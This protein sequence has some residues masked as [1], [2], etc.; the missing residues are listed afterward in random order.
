MEP[1]GGFDHNAQALRVVTLLERRYA[2]YDGLDLTWETLEGSSNTMARSRGPRRRVRFPRYV[3]EFDA[4]FPLELR[5]FASVEAQAAA[6]ADDIA[7]NR[8]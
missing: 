1:Y 8:A 4:P 3:A 5:T 7:Y 6:H 2:A